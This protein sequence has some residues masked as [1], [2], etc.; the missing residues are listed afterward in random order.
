MN[1]RQKLKYITYN[2]IPGIAGTFPYFGVKVHFPR[3]SL[4]FK[5]ACDHGIYEYNNITILRA[6]IRGN[7]TML[8]VGANIG[9]MAIPILSSCRSCNVVSFEPSATVL[10]YLRATISES[11]FRDRWELVEKA[12]GSHEGSAS[13]SISSSSESAYD[14]FRYTN[15]A[16][17]TQTI[18]VPVTTIDTTWKSLKRPN[19]SIIKCDV[20]GAEIDTLE[21]A[22]ECI[23]STKPAILAEWNNANLSAYGRPADSLLRFS[24]K[25]GY[26]L[27]SIPNIAAISN[28]EALSFEMLRTESF[29]LVPSAKFLYHALAQR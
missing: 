26:R 6:L 24:E 12:A 17:S 14:G 5:I 13:F 9:L 21:G 16:R 22:E 25:I 2:H 3:N 18:Q 19:I 27:F 8:D 1:L 4:I 28:N 23:A 29:L 11:Q 15:R 10:P 20:E 7:T